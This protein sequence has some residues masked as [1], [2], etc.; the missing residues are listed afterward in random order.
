MHLV[1]L[2]DEK[3]ADHLYYVW[4]WEMVN[5]GLK[6][7]GFRLIWLDFVWLAP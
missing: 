4:M 5:S 6:I 2:L 7:R 3:F 1:P